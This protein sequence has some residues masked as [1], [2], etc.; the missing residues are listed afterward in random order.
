MTRPRSGL[1]GTP[2]ER[3]IRGVCL[4]KRLVRVEEPMR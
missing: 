3:R 1:Q 2:A 4:G